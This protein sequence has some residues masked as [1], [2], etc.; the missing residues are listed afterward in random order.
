MIA[1]PIRILP[2]PSMLTF[3][4]YW[5]ARR[6]PASV[7]L[8]LGLVLVVVLEA[9]PGLFEGH[10]RVPAD[11]HGQ[12]VLIGHAVPAPDG[13]GLLDFSEDPSQRLCGSPDA[14]D[15]LAGAV[16]RTPDVV[17]VVTADRPGEPVSRPEEVDGARLPVVAGED[18]GSISL[19][20]G[21]LLVDPVYSGDEALPAEPV[22][23]VLGK[24]SDLACLDLHPGISAGGA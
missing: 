6:C 10:L 4:F 5:R 14:Y 19:L 1:T 17:A 12:V 3:L 13:I 23:E 22:G 24:L 9:G 8:R 21:Q 11:V 18:A 2:R 20:R 15:D 16:P 7:T